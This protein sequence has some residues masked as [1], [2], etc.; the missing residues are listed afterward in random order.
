[1]S[2]A[3]IWRGP[4]GLSFRQCLRVSAAPTGIA[5]LLAV[6][7]HAASTPELVDG[8][9]AAAA[10]PWLTLPLFVVA[11]T[12]CLAAAHTWPLFAQRQPGADSIRRIERSLF[13]GRLAIIAG[14]LAAQ[15]LLSMPLAMAMSAWLDAP[16]TARRHHVATTSAQPIM[17]RVGDSLTFALDD[18]PQVE[19]LL[20]RPRAAMPTGDGATQV[21]I[22]HK[23]KLLATTPV[24]FAESGALLR[25]EI[26]PQQLDQLE[27]TKT[28]GHVPLLFHEAS[29]IAVGPAEMPTWCNSLLAALIATW[30]SAITL[31][32]AAIVGTGTGWATLATT[33]GCV[34][35][36][37]WIGGI[38]PIDD[39]LLQLMRGQWLW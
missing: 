25:V 2:W 21:S 32:I 35:F 14:A 28:A 33:I 29:V 11:V 16:G 26:Q 24:A 5:V 3:V 13:Q 27:L 4:T 8:Y 39:A 34:Q 15:C 22:T 18:A 36:V 17:N 9:A 10:T 19:A 37:Q 1:M 20:L 23:G 30:T 6:I 12:C 31:L 7:A 38:G